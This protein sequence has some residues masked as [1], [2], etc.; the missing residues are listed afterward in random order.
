VQ[1]GVSQNHRVVRRADTGIGNPWI[2]KST[3]G[4][5][6]EGT[7]EGMTSN[8]L[9]VDDDQQ[10]RGTVRDVLEDEGCTVHEAVDD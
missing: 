5:P 9:V 7:E 4:G 10:L 8:I 2:S 3:D 6:S 1:V